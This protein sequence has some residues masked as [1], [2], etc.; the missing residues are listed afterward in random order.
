MKTE[1]E[2]K[3]MIET[4][5]EIGRKEENKLQKAIIVEKMGVL[6]WVLKD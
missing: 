6:A 4:M 2:I 1:K 3:E 5:R